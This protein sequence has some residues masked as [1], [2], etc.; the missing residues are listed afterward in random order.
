MQL[1]LKP[2]KWGHLKG[3]K[4]CSLLFL[5]SGTLPRAE[6]TCVSCSETAW[7][8]YVPTG[9]IQSP[10]GFLSIHSLILTPGVVSSVVNIPMRFC[11]V[12]KADLKV[13][14]FS[15]PFAAQLPVELHLSQVTHRWT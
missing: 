8:D 11:K 5:P 2:Q 13:S 4:L 12:G 6:K 14:C 9:A 15:K 7:Q 1:L 10:G 3:C